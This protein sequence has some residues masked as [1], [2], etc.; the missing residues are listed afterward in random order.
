MPGGGGA[1]GF[2]EG[3][4]RREGLAAP[5]LPCGG[6]GGIPTV[7]A[8]A[9]VAEEFAFGAGEEL[10]GDFFRGAGAVVVG[11]D[12]G[13]RD[14]GEF[15]G[16]FGGLAGEAEG[17]GAFG[18]DDFSRKEIGGGRNGPGGFFGADGEDDVSAVV[19][20]PAGGDEEGLEE[21]G[22]VAKDAVGEVR[23]SEVGGEVAGRG[24]DDSF[25]EEEG[26]GCRGIPEDFGEEF[27]GVANA[28]RMHANYDAEA[29]GRRA[30]IAEGFEGGGGGVLGD[31][32]GAAE[33]WMREERG[34]RVWSWDVPDGEIF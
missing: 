26:A 25:G 1:E 21:R 4:A 17:A 9:A 20:E 18:A 14:G 27:F 31:G 13:V 30:E 19:G 3:C 10:G 11:V 33:A 5:V 29:L 6:F 28:G 16:V 32:A 15:D 8:G 22:L 34:A 7:C 2:T 24:V 12:G 23:G